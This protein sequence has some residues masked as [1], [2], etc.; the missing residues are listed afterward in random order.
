MGAVLIGTLAGVA[1]VS[2]RTIRFYERRGLL[3]PID[4]LGN[5]YRYYD[6]ATVDRL[7]FI[8][9]AQT[10]GLTLAEIGSILA[11]TRRRP[12]TVRSRHPTP[13]GQARG[14][15]CTPATARPARGRARAAD[16]SERAGEPHRLHE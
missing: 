13:R 11:L 5:G 10:R 4:R 12:A 1:G 14:C 7:G 9:S 3:H 8:Q 16:R 6:D 2:P 15:S